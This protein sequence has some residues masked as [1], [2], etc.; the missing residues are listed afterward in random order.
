MFLNEDG[1]KPNQKC[2]VLEGPKKIE[3]WMKYYVKC[4]R[5]NYWIVADNLSEE[6]IEEEEEEIEED[7]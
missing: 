3:G 1:S 7:A 2:T 6:E 5:K 4:G